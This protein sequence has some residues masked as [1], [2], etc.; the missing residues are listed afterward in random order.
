MAGDVIEVR[1]PDMLEWQGRRYRCALGRGGI[2]VDKREGD[3]GTPIGVHPLR[4]VLYRPDRL[5]MV[6]TGLPLA[7]L[8]PGD[9]WCDDPDDPAY[10]C[11]VPLP[12][13]GRHERLW[14]EDGVYDVVAVL[15]WNDDPPVAGRGSAI[16]LHVARPGYEPTEGCVAL[17]RTDL[18]EVL[19]DCG[20]RTLMRIRG[21]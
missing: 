6:A 19:A 7:M 4:R 9:G 3:G 12:Y 11:L 10:N 1:A 8:H 16:F 13:P 2:V 18:L 15:G 20:P 14:R 21:G 17:A 5:V